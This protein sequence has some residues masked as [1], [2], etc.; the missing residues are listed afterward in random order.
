MNTNTNIELLRSNNLA[1]KAEIIQ[2]GMFQN[3]KTGMSETVSEAFV[4]HFGHNILHTD[5]EGTLMYNGEPLK[6]DALYQEVVLTEENSTETVNFSFYNYEYSMAI[7]D[8]TIEMNGRNRY[9]TLR[10]TSQ[11]G[12]I[13]TNVF[14]DEPKT[15]GSPLEGISFNYV[16]PGNPGP[17][18]EVE[19]GVTIEVSGYLYQ[20]TEARVK[21]SYYYIK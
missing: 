4:L 16:E 5:A 1:F 20:G 8:Y 12:I 19:E 3:P 17:E 15:P 2:D 14:Y 21:L 11:G 10:L 6:G 7:V 9:G 18:E 13:E